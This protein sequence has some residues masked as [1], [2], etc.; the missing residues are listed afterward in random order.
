MVM[1]SLGLVG[2]VSQPYLKPEALKFQEHAKNNTVVLNVQRDAKLCAG[3]TA[4]RQDCAIQFYIDSI[5]AGRFYINNTA[6]YYLKPE[7]YNFKVKNCNADSCQSC[8][9]DL[10]AAELQNASLMLSL[11][12][13]GKPLIQQ[14][15]QHLIC[16]KD[17]DQAAL[18]TPSEL[19]QLNIELAADTL[20]KFDGSAESDLLAKGNQELLNVARQI[21]SEFVS[22]QQ[23]NLVGHTD[24]LG[25]AVYN[26]VL[27]QNRANTVRNILIKNGVESAVI[28][29][30][31]M[32]KT[33]PITDGCYAVKERE[34]LR[35]CLQP[36][37]RV[38]V[39]ILGISH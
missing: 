25:T 28:T 14:Q 37:R 12:E 6:Q 24:R 16:S 11:D 18:N 2:C 38:S 3:E 30:Q 26:Q 22:V 21:S 35:A 9:V 7:N 15:G 19:K 13:N 34:A 1:L 17:K 23:I 4:D 20:F 8:D 27:G 31:S 29:T 32:G 33:Q 36:D 10:S 39:E 5:Q